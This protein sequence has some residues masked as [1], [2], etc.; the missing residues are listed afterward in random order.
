M[1]PCIDN[2]VLKVSESPLNFTASGSELNENTLI[3]ANDDFVKKGITIK[4]MP[5]SQK[6]MTF[7]QNFRVLRLLQIKETI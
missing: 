1:R 7:F 6:G 3:I 5:T 2:D 4:L